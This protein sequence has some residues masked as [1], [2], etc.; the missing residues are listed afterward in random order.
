MRADAVLCRVKPSRNRPVKTTQ[1]SLELL[2]VIKD[3]EGA[4]ISDLTATTGLARST[5]HNHLQTLLEMGYVVRENNTYYVGLWLFHL[6]QHSRTRKR[7]YEYG[8]RA[9]QRL[10]DVTDKVAVFGVEENGRLINLFH[11][12]GDASGSESELGEYSHLHCTAAG[13][14]ILAALPEERRDDVLETH[15]LPA[16][17][18]ETITDRQALEAALETVRER[19][20]AMENGE[21]VP[22]YKAVGTALQYPDGR[23]FGGVAI[24]GPTDLL[25][26][27]RTEK[28]RQRRAI[29]GDAYTLEDDL[30]EATLSHLFEVAEDV[31]ADLASDVSNS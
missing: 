6:G 26:R 18:E 27:Q 8:K 2:E 29:G 11:E 1:T 10:A 4:T 31:E 20:Y 9:V 25:N 16:R 17:T 15:G 3:L 5:A 14:A 28:E 23:V 12:G 22:G 21:R 30:D 19:E 13:K 7:A 24:G